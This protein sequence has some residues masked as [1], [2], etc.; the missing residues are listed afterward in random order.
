MAVSV[1]RIRRWLAAAALAAALAVAGVYF[2]SRHNAQNA[3]KQVPGKIGLE[4]KQSASG[5]TISKSEQGRTLFKIEA[6]KAIQFRQ[7]GRAELHDVAI[8]LFGRDSTRYDRIYGSDFTYD[9]QSGNVTASGEVQIDLEA[10]P[11]GLLNPDQAPP[12]ELKS[13]IHLKTSGLVFNQ[14]TGNAYTKQKVEFTLPQATGSALGSLPVCGG[15]AGSAS[16]A[17][18]TTSWMLRTN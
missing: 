17:L 4:I 13:P 2:Y 9:Q 7:G 12:K 5:F 18:S 11:E 15:S 14:K 16:S 3:L 10:N 6:S 8:T 1:S